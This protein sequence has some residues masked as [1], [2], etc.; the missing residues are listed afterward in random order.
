VLLRQGW[1]LL[2]RIWRTRGLGELFFMTS[3]RG[4][5]RAFMKATNPPAFPPAFADHLYELYRDKGTRRAVLALY[6]ATPMPESA[7][8]I[9]PRL[10]EHPRPTLVVWGAKDPYLPVALAR[11]QR[12]VFR[13]AHVIELPD[14]GH[15]PLAD[16]PDAVRDAVLPFLRRQAADRA[17][18]EAVET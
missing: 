11:R 18:F 9:A 4:G 6:R 16:D 14:S 13:D 2:A 5:M 12:E 8:R 10:R 1:H 7:E 17:A 3:T 15:W